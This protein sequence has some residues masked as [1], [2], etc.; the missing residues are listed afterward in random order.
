VQVEK[1]LAEFTPGR[2]TVLTV[3]V[4]DGVHLGHKR[5]ISELLRKA[6]KR[7]LLAG[8][9]TFRQHP[10]DI[11]SKNMKLPFLTDIETRSKL[12]KKAGVD[13]I[14]LLSFTRELAGLEARGFVGLLQKYLRMRGLVVGPD[15]A[16]GKGR[17]GD[18][19]A[20]AEL[21][22]EMDFDVTVVPP[23]IIDNEV[24]SSTTIRKAMAEGNMEKYRKFTGRSFNLHGKV[25]A[26]TGRGCGLGFPTANLNVNE[27]QALP[28]DG[29]YAGW[30]HANGKVYRSMNNVGLCP[31]FD[32][33]ER[34]V[35]A[36]LLDY[37]GDLYGH[38]LTVDFI[39]KLRD[40]KK[41]DSEAELKAQLTEDVRKGKEILKSVGANYDYY[42]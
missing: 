8:V 41:F 12:L 29:V 9:V 24:V 13:F 40:E 20:L 15:F 19:T 21:G 7:H 32:G 22:K 28:P 26:G 38:E 3:G 37:N 34:T 11:F 27:G 2:D 6:R 17:K 14:V 33:T 18:A 35:E 25:V 42:R 16:M 36:Y 23:L 31:T 1:E 4:F 10:E 5:L 39:A 30:A